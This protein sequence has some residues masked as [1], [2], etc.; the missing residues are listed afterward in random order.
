[1]GRGNDHSLLGG[2]TNGAAWW[3]NDLEIF[4]HKLIKNVQRGVFKKMP[5]VEFLH[6]NGKDA[7][8]GEMILKPENI[9][10]QTKMKKRLWE[11]QQF[12]LIS[13]TDSTQPWWLGGR[14]VD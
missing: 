2:T 1:M 9:R 3:K 10:D 8:G 7:H 11:S 13:T 6:K 14:G 5:M 4:T 12:S